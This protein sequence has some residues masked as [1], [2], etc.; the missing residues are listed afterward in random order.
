M[1]GAPSP[2]GHRTSTEA[3]FTVP[4][5]LALLAA[6]AAATISSMSV[7]S[8][9]VPWELEGAVEVEAAAAAAAEEGVPDAAAAG[10]AATL[11]TPKPSAGS[12]HINHVM[13]CTLC[14][15][16]S[17]AL[18]SGTATSSRSTWQ[19]LNKA[20]QRGAARQPWPTGFSFVAQS[21]VC[22]RTLTLQ[23]GKSEQSH[24]HCVCGAGRWGQ[25]RASKHL[26]TANQTRLAPRPAQAA[27]GRAPHPSSH[28][29]SY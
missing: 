11:V 15:G 13:Q 2:S 28:T 19:P 9:S 24:A 5:T 1:H 16:V 29:C 17:C 22:M 27:P 25:Q 23:R 7:L 26:P 18:L 20:E 3:R 6:T 10:S 12:K 4:P 14:D 21:T 8:P